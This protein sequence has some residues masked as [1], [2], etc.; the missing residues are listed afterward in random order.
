M[1]STVHLPVV[2]FEVGR[3]GRLHQQ[4]LD[5]P[6]GQLAA[7]MTQGQMAVL[8]WVCKAATR[9]IRGGA[10]GAGLVPGLEE[11]SAGS[12]PCQGSTSQPLCKERFLVI[13]P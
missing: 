6:P 12:P 1:T 9:P 2:C 4:V 8:M 11:G 5:V 10:L 3:P 13:K 7:A